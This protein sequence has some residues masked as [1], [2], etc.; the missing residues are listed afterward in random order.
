MHATLATTE[1]AELPFI[2][3]C[4]S[5]KGGRDWFLALRHAQIAFHTEDRLLLLYGHPL[6]FRL[7]TVC[8]RGTRLGR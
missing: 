5:D 1:P 7:G 3:P 8:R 2:S 6:V 4:D